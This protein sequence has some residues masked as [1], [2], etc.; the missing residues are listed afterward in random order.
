MAWIYLAESVDSPLHSQIGCGQS[1]IVKSIDTV[2]EFY[3]HEWPAE[4]C[5]PH[6]YKRTLSFWTQGVLPKSQWTSS[7]AGSRARTS[8]LQELGQVWGE[9]KAD[10]F[11]K[12]SDLQKKLSRRLCSSKMYQGLEL[13]DFEESSENLPIWGMSAVGLVFLPQK[14]EPRTY[15]KDGSYWPTPNAMRAGYNQGGAQGRIGKKRPTWWTIFGQVPSPQITEYAMGY[16]KNW[17]ELKDWATQW[18]RSRP[19][20]HSKD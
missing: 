15:A 6:Q 13:A 2:R 7:M 11:S 12:S 1:P 19:K 4:N 14:L 10:F 5:Q 8:V 16:P 9:S 18:F 20:K 17:T 3:Y